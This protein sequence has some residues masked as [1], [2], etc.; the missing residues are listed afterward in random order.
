MPVV[1]S[2]SSHPGMFCRPP[3]HGHEL[4]MTPLHERRPLS[5]SSSIPDQTMLTGLHHIEK[6][7]QPTPQILCHAALFFIL[8]NLGKQ[9]RS[10]EIHLKPQILIQKSL[11]VLYLL[12]S[13]TQLYTPTYS[14]TCRPFAPRKKQFR[15][16]SLKDLSVE[17][18][19]QTRLWII[20][21]PEQIPAD[22]EA[23][24]L[25]WSQLTLLWGHSKMPSQSM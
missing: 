4:R 14:F 9:P 8:S 25:W 22:T 10:Q 11:R 12:A 1:N 24:E 20:R 21:F 19:S 16:P 6:Q 13:F 17:Q 7:N 2:W 15:I 3:G 18:G 5:L 23:Q